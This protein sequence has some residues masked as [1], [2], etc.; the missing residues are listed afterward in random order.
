MAVLRT[1]TV[2]DL[3]QLLDLS[4][5]ANWNQLEQDWRN[6]LSLAPAGCIGVEEDGR[7]VASATGV[8]YGGELAWIGM[9]L[10]RP[11]CRGR[12]YASQLMRQLLEHLQTPCIKLDAT[13]LGRPIYEKLGF[14]E[15]YVVER[16]MGQLPAAPV[17]TYPPDPELDRL[18][19]GADRSA[20]LPLLGASR[21]G[22]VAHYLGP[23]VART[24]VEARARIEGSGAAG[25][26]YWDIPVPNP[27]ATALAAELGFTPVR[28]LWRMRRG[29]PIQE[30]PD[31]VYALAGFEWG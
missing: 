13:D 3:P 23:I 27:Q 6:L 24:P 20:L 4:F 19:F 8:A 12:G 25:T 17:I 9:V 29:T 26:V 1:F 16:W 5:S 18:A 14:V 22:R 10:T 7:I 11:E 30:R 21:P 2:A 28:R 31:L 15:E